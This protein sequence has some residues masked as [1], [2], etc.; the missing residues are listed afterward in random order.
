ME[1]LKFIIL[2]GYFTA[3]AGFSLFGFY[4]LILLVLYLKNRRQDQV[5][6]E[7]FDE[8]PPVTIQLPI[9]N[10]MYVAERLV[11]TCCKIR[12][13]RHLLEIQVLDD[14]TDDTCPIAK[15]VV[16]EMCDQGYDVKY[17]HRVD[18]KDFK[19]GALANG[20]KTARGEYVAIFDAD[21]LPGED[22]L[23][24]TVHFFKDD[25]IGMVQAR[26]GFINEKQSLLTRIQT[27]FLNGH[28]VIEHTSR[29]R[30]GRF[31]NFN[32]TA[33]IWRKEAIASAGGWQGDTLTE[34][35]DLSYRAQLKGW[36]FIYLKD[37]VVPSELPV[38]VN[39]LKGQ[40]FRWVK[41]MTEV[42][43]KLMPYIWKS[44]IPFYK[45]I[46]ST[47]HLLSNTG[48]I[49]TTLMALLVV[50]TLYMFDHFFKSMAVVPLVYFFITNFVAV[51]L[52][53]TYAE[54]EVG[55]RGLAKIRDVFLLMVVGIGL[56]INGTKAILEAVRGKKTKF[57]R[58]PKFSATNTSD[59]DW[60]KRKYVKKTD[61]TFFFEVIFALYF[62][63]CAFLVFTSGN[64]YYVFP[65]C[66]FGPGYFYLIYHSI[67]SK[68]L[69]RRSAS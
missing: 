54:S 50:P 17:I 7:L 21:F 49:T 1:I 53:F 65:L 20:L 44:N 23:E 30:A 4:K 31:F 2:T 15:K 48:Y 36:K 67:K 47:L 58:T 59:N 8:L 37:L 35:L 39:G 57:I 26:W 5:P 18:R 27:V 14:S 64:V 33:G 3:L 45:K 29:H 40:Q 22:F 32:G 56:S 68:R 12:Y 41:G 6:A 24:K 52:Y 55:N 60:H 63:W 13:P 42:C 61:N 34:D 46:D 51:F 25:K 69:V 66:F 43:I 16:Q 9:Y 38:E 62:L 28:F 19:A 11:K 10:E